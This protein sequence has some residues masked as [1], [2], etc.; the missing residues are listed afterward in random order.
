MFEIVAMVKSL[1]NITD[2]EQDEMILFHV[3]IVHRQ[4]LI[5]CNLNEL[6]RELFFETA[7]MVAEIVNTSAGANL[8]GMP[9]SSVSEAG[10]TVQFATA[11]M[12]EMSAAQKI[13]DRKTQL[14]RFKRL[15]AFR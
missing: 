6:P 2:D 9:V 3:E 4:I 11:A 12:I 8:N 15:Y 13:N 1:L 7:Q 5:Y 14:N 10:R